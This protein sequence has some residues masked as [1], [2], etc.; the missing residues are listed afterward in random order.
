MYMHPAVPS[1]F[2]FRHG[3]RKQSSLSFGTPRV[4][5]HPVTIMPPLQKKT[6]TTPPFAT[7]R[8]YEAKRFP[9]LS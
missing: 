2:S 5:E 8:P 1:A 7:P 4:S 3:S 6:H 9:M